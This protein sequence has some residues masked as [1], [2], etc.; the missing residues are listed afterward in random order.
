M[1]T[2]VYVATRKEPQH[3]I[4]LAVQPHRR[5]SSKVGGLQC[6]IHLHLENHLRAPNRQELDDQQGNLLVLTP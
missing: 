5:T 2:L 1:V 4:L 3:R 6:T